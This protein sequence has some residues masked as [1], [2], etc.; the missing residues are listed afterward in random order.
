MSEV[1]IPVTEQTDSEEHIQAMVAKA[2]GEQPEA[3]PEGNPELA[4][5]KTAEELAKAYQEL[6]T[7]MSSEGAP[8]ADTQ[9]TEGETEETTDQKTEGDAEEAQAAATKAV[10]DAGF[11]MSDLETEFQEKG[12]LSDET[13]A[14]LEKAGFSKQDVSNYIAGQQ[15]L[16]EQVQ[17]R[18][19]AHVGGADKLNAAIGWAKEN[20]SPEEATAFNKAIDQ[21]DE[22]GIKLALDGLMAKYKADQGDEP[23]LLGGGKASTNGN[24]FQSV[25]ELTA[26]M[27]DPRY[28][29]DPA[30]RA[31]VEKRLAKS[32][33]F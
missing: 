33:I 13:Y 27:R 31:D 29:K 4:G 30:Y 18:I 26:A 17:S 15:A 25:A 28:Q 2:N 3:K 20:F 10:E 23:N 11:K 6:R 24:V 7:K 16:A 5:F 19:E 12:E 22:A 9:Q 14:K 8:K 32:S 21:A 1:Q